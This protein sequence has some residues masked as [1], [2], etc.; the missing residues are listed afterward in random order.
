MLA[1]IPARSGSKGLP[2]K[3]LRQLDGRPLVAWP[4][5]AALGANSVSR[6]IVST[7]D[8]AIANIAR[9]SGAD[10]P[11]MRPANLASDTASS[12]DVVLHALD[13][14]AAQ[15][16]EFQYVMLL[17]PTSP[18][19][20][21]SDIDAAFSRLV[22]TSNLADAIVGISHVEST[23]PEYDV[24]LG[25]NGLISPYAASDFSSLRRRQ[26]IEPLYFLEGSLYISQ[27]SAFKRYKTFYHNRTIGYEVP[28]WKSIE[29][30]DLFDFIVIEAIVKWRD[31]LLRKN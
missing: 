28:R 8:E 7:D 14:L 13:V 1:I 6:V 15:G 17:E 16:E 23:H 12:M 31:E 22:A 11:F 5:S 20:E 9:A 10:V 29:V 26:D 19:T 24:R 21:S 27:V 30:D 3:N 2:G 4:I 18:L 25:E